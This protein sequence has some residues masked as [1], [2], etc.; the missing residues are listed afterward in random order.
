MNIRRL[1]GFI[2]V[3]FLAGLAACHRAPQTAE[4]KAQALLRQLTLD[5]KIG[6]MT[7]V[8]SD[9]LIGHEQDIAACFLGSILSGGNSNPP[10]NS[11]K[12][13]K[14]F[15][16]R[17]DAY[18]L[19]TRLRIPIIYGI[20]AVHGNNNVPNAT[21]FPHN[22]GLGATRD[23]ELV[24]RA[25]RVTAA[26]V[27]A[28]GV[29]WAFAPCV[30]VAQDERW[31]RTY[32]SFGE[33]PDL[34]AAMGAATVA[35]L[36]GADVAARD[37][38]LSCTKHFL[39][40]G[41]TTG[42]RDQGDTRVDFETLKR[43]HLPGYIAAIKAGTKSIM[44]SFS[45]W[46]GLK[47][48]AQRP[49][50]TDLLKGEL[51]FSGFVVSDWAAIDQINKG[52]Y[53]DCVEKAINAGIDMVM[54]PHSSRA[55]KPGDKPGKTYNTFYDF[56]KYLKELVA[57]GKVPQSRI[58]DAV[59]RILRVKF[60][61]GMFEGRKDAPLDTIG[62]RQHRDVAR[63]CVRKSLV[64]LQNRNDLLPLPKQARRIGITGRA[65]KNL[66]LQCGGWT[67]DWQSTN[68]AEIEGGTTI[69]DAVQKTVTSDTRI[70]LS[71]DGT[72][73]EGCSVVIAAVGEDSY[74]E[75]RGDREDL[76][77]DP[78]DLQAVANAGKSGAPIV[79]VLI[80]GRPMLI[81]PLLK[82][83]DAVVAA[84][85][86]G[87]EGQGV[88]DVLFGDYKP[89]GKL[90]CSWPRSMAQIPINAGAPGYDPLFPYGFGLTYK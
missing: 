2:V 72:G 10:E 68:G 14:D 28:I 15:V 38:I 64:L 25:A 86:P 74:A 24:T 46:N 33:N 80:S 83:C 59:L 67:I 35:G 41:G 8:D 63:E 55:P 56:I 9:A 69:F 17:L 44:A 12:G 19:K 88:A 23:A 65:A 66:N 77:L 21:I 61:L 27:A 82:Q 48:H 53:K 49:L 57:E 75:G 5:E 40:D 76:S 18:A 1:Q 73:L 20:D 34:V 71:P 78:A 47:M 29:D 89:T 4:E 42:G 79:A 39:G 6:Q 58:D 50:I 26:E 60:E 51:G 22:I 90:P 37:S 87:S 70:V 31:G 52:D 54:I 30:A 81:D 84:W 3:A 36:Q 85:L 11:A 13:W 62:S 7:Q 43:I 32:E 45:S 16:A